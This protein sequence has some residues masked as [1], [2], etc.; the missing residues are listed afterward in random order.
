MPLLCVQNRF[1]N[2]SYVGSIWS[3]LSKKFIAV[4]SADSKKVKEGGGDTAD[5]TAQSRPFSPADQVL[6]NFAVN[7]CLCLLIQD[8]LLVRYLDESICAKSGSAM[9]LLNSPFKSDKER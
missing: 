9:K 5:D 2:R 8:L 4:F 1:F 6:L 7:D 3:K